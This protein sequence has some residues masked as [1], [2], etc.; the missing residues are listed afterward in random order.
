M[1]QKLYDWKETVCSDWMLSSNRR[2]ELVTFA[3]DSVIFY[4]AD[5]SDELKALAENDLKRIRDLRF[6][7]INL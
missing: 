7:T 3:D 2:G 5:K 1:V 6:S 4:Q